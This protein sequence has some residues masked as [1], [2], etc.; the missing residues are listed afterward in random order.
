M[1]LHLFIKI[2][3]TWSK[4]HQDRTSVEVV[5]RR[6]VLLEVKFYLINQKYYLN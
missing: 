3:H 4:S 5:E 6:R 1:N 2:S